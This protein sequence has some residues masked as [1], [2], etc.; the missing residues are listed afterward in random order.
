MDVIFKE[1]D[2][3]QSYYSNTSVNKADNKNFDFN[4]S[5]FHFISIYK[6]NTI[7]KRYYTVSKYSL[8]NNFSYEGS[9][10]YYKKSFGIDFVDKT[11]LTDTHVQSWVNKDSWKTESR[12]VKLDKPRAQVFYGIDIPT[13][14]QMKCIGNGKLIDTFSTD[15]KMVIYNFNADSAIVFNTYDIKP[16]MHSK[17]KMFNNKTL[18]EKSPFGLIKYNKGKSDKSET[19]FTVTKRITKI[20]LL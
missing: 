6:N 2:I 14:I 11:S 19:N 3:A 9:L 8:H 1:L 20:E 12:T 4:I 16:K 5:G 17:N 15:T 13:G 7:V 18:V 10:A